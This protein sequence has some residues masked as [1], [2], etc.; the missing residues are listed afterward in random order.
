MLK[1]STESACNGSSHPSSLQA[2]D[3]GEHR[4]V[5]SPKN[6]VAVWLRP[7]FG[8]GLRWHLFFKRTGGLE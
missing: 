4:G 8:K 5:Q 7:K 2:L 1:A 6:D 3:E